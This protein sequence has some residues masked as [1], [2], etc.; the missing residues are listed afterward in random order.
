MPSDI[1][2]D[3]DIRMVQC[4]GSSRLT[5]QGNSVRLYTLLFAIRQLLHLV[6]DLL[7]ARRHFELGNINR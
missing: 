6:F 2:N 3:L 5:W 1:V 4:G 7:E